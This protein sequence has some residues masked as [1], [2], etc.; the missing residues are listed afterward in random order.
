M[1]RETPFL[2]AGGKKLR[3]AITR[4]PVL[5]ARIRRTETGVRIKFSDGRIAWLDKDG[6]VSEDG[7]LGS[8]TQ[9]VQRHGA[10][11]IEIID[12]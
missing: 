10:R 3:Q 1:L 5:S 6:Q 9:W 12:E 4:A 8:V 11:S 7:F 2:P